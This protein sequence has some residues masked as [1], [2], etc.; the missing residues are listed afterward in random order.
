MKNSILILL[1]ALTFYSCAKKD[2]E[3]PD[4]DVSTNAL[5]YKVGD[6][7]KFNFTGKPDMISFYSG[8]QGSRYKYIKRVDVSG[9]PTLQFTSFASTV[10]TQVN[11]LRVLASV[12][13]GG[14]YDAV[15]IA[16]A[17]WIDLTSRAVISSGTDNTASGTIDLSDIDAVG[18][19]VYFA[20]SRH[21]DNDP[22]KRPWA[23]IIRSFNI[24][25]LANDDGL[26]YPVTTI[27]TAGWKPV[28]VL[29]S[30]YKWVVSTTTLTGAAGPVNTPENEDWVIT[31][32]LYLYKVK[33][34]VAVSIK[35][36][37]AN[38]DNYS[39]VFKAPGTYTVTFIARN[40]NA[41]DE[42]QVV[43]EFNIVVQ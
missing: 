3:V 41:N 39:Y 19:P 13:F 37:D 23:W 25:L 43:K 24:S 4:F 1:I 38:V 33:P 16:K 15:G 34:D 42:K 2:V 36:I 18:K 29:N 6:P 11:T 21:D 40:V 9:K 8:E 20:F 27:A 14:S 35:T 28:D 7:V 31:N 32:P 26:S 22:A 10:G 30:T 12:D 5:N 17:T